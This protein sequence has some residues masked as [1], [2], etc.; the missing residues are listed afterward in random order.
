MMLA[1]KKAEYQKQNIVEKGLKRQKDLLDEK[2]KWK[3]LTL[4]VIAV[5]VIL[6]IIMIVRHLRASVNKL[7]VD[8]I[9]AK[10]EEQ[11]K[12][13]FSIVSTVRYADL[14]IRLSV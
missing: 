13:S 12:Q 8:A 11:A 14:L 2:I 5:F 7:K 4:V 10:R 3:T 9:R 6:F 1:R